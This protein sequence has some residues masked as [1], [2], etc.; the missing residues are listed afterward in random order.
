MTSMLIFCAGAVFFSL[1]ALV[2][3]YK[4]WGVGVFIY[5]ILAISFGLGSLRSAVDVGYGHV[6]EVAE[7][8]SNRLKTGVSYQVISSFKDGN[9]EVVF[10]KP[11]RVDKRMPELYAIRVK[12]GGLPAT[13]FT[14][15]DSNPVTIIQP[16]TK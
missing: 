9:D 11:Y 10:V 3:A 7:P 13:Y 1:I 8:L 2:S 14:M 4:K 12:E 15:I 6:S 5:S 16:Q